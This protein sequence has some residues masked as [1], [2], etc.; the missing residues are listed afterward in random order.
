MIWFIKM[1]VGSKVFRIAALALVATL[2]LY[3]TITWWERGIRNQTLQ[4]V[5]TQ[6]LRQNIQ[7]RN[8]VDEA[9]RSS[10]REF[11]SAVEWLRRRNSG[12]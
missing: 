4:E 12:E 11:D 9:V 6:Q 10:P 5:E 3:A 1:F 7:T 2:T 8:R